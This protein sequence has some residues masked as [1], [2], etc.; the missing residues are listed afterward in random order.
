MDRALY[1]RVRMVTMTDRFDQWLSYSLVEQL[2]P[3][4]GIPAVPARARYRQQRLRATAGVLRRLRSST[5]GK[6]VLA[7]A[8]VALIGTV[9]AQAA[10][11]GPVHLEKDG[12]HFTLGVPATP[13]P[14]V[15]MPT[16]T[17]PAQRAL[18]SPLPTPE[19]EATPA[20]SASR[21]HDSSSGVQPSESPEREYSSTSPQ[22]SAQPGP[23][24]SGGLGDH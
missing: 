20:P 6:L 11:Y 22:G 15:L 5:A 23:T 1:R 10:G 4:Y 19:R 9:G 2:N 12:V 18:T 17:A 8:T 13:N 14:P 3:A 21:E 16:P 24:E 7:T